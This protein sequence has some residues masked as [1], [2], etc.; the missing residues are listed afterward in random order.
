MLPI[1]SSHSYLKAEI[2]HHVSFLRESMKYEPHFPIRPRWSHVNITLVKLK[3]HSVG[4]A[5]GSRGEIIVRSFYS[6]SLSISNFIL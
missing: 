3:L 4:G 1:K 5:M 2:K 6:P